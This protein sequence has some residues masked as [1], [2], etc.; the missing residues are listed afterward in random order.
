MTLIVQTAAAADAP[1]QTDLLRNSIHRLA[2][3]DREITGAILGGSTAAGDTKIQLFVGDVQVAELVNILLTGN[4]AGTL[5]G[6]TLFP[7]DAIVPGGAELRAIVS[8][9]PT[10]NPVT[11]YIEIDE[12]DDADGMDGLDMAMGDAFG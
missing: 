6:Y 10:G 4:G 11:L 7:I 2:S 12:L 9:A 3:E 1:L 8:D 5:T